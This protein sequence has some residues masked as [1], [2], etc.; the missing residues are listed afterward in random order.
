MLQPSQTDSNSLSDFL[1]CLMTG[2]I[3]LF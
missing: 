1:I 3:I 2:T